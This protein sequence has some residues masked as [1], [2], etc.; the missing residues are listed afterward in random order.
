MIPCSERFESPLVNQKYTNWITASN[1]GWRSELRVKKQKVLRVKCKMVSLPY[2][3]RYVKTPSLTE[4]GSP[5]NEPKETSTGLEAVTFREDYGN[6]GIMMA[7]PQCVRA[8]PS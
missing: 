5:V 2:Y 7:S 8:S 1:A 3:A 6:V 4:V